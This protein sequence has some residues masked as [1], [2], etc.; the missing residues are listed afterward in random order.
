MTEK[1]ID[2]MEHIS[3]EQL[4]KLGFTRESFK[5]SNLKLFMESVMLSVDEA[6]KDETQ[7]LMKEHSLSF[8]EARIIAYERVRKSLEKMTKGESL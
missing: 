7:K 2:L 3:D 8:G 6:V 4:E 5:D 1:Q